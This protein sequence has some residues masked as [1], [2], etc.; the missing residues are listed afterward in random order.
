MTR[1]CIVIICTNGCVLDDPK[2]QVWEEEILKKLEVQPRKEER[3]SRHH[4]HAWKERPSLS[5]SIKNSIKH[6]V[7]LTKSDPSLIS[8]YVAWRLSEVR[9]VRIE[10]SKG[11]VSVVGIVIEHIALRL[12]VLHYLVVVIV[13]IGNLCCLVVGLGLD[14]WTSYCLPRLSILWAVIR[15][16]LLYLSLSL[17]CM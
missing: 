8:I 4:C 11:S 17:R 2:C 10:R 6:S 15:R 7:S 12:L 9:I 13:N 1:P 16:C 3:A 14:N 5:L